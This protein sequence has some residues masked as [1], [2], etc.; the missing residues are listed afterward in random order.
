M[1]SNF[2]SSA[3]HLGQILPKN[4]RL[5]KGS[6][7]TKGLD[8][9]EGEKLQR[10]GKVSHKVFKITCKVY[11]NSREKLKLH[12]IKMV[13]DFYNIGYYILLICICCHKHNCMCCS[14]LE[15]FY[16]NGFWQFICNDPGFATTESQKS[17]KD[18]TFNI[19]N[20]KHNVCVPN[21]TAPDG[22][23]LKIEEKLT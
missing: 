5:H 6:C 8:N 21:V 3:V 10:A 15:M 4:F 7:A 20:L 2:W 16:F 18:P 9:W 19:L 1:P 14:T 23:Q 17:L 22:N 11:L 13:S 12:K